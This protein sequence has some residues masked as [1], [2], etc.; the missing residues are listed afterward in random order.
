[1]RARRCCRS[2]L[3]IRIWMVD[4]NGPSSS[5]SFLHDI[6]SPSSPAFPLET[7]RLP[8]LLLHHPANYQN[9]DWKPTLSSSHRLI[10][11]LVDLSPL[12]TI[13][14]SSRQD[15]ESRF[16][17][18]SKIAFIVYVFYLFLFSTPLFYSFFFSFL[19]TFLFAFPSSFIVA[20]VLSM[21]KRYTPPNPQLLHFYLL[22]TVLI[23]C[24]FNHNTIIDC[25]FMCTCFIHSFNTPLCNFCLWFCFSSF[26]VFTPCRTTLK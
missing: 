8:R 5:S 4:E 24:P 16:I 6:R 12:R 17:Q 26:R 15:Q 2:R 11:P 20:V 9:S 19:F 21:L 7:L 3:L 23:F 18:N 22:P 10:Y 13:H 1:M 14:P 25:H